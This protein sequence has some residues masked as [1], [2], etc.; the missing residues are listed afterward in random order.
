MP[1]SKKFSFKA[2]IYKVGINWCVDVP[3]EV[4]E[5]L[6]KDKGKIHIKGK[7]NGFDFIKTLVPVKDAPHRLYVNQA[8]MSGGNT[9]L[10][11][12]TTFQIEQNLEKIVKEY[13]LPILLEREL[14]QKNLTDEFTKLTQ[15]QKREILKYLSYIKTE[16]TLQKNID[17][18]ITKLERKEKNIRIP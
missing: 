7:I 18:L 5:Q 1:V 12:I 2:K 3:N 6:T 11:K 13:P 15:A 4:G 10:G 17:K 9:A 8:M 14:K 16:E